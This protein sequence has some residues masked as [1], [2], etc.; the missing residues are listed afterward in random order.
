MLKSGTADIDAASKL[1][2]DFCQQGRFGA[3]T[4]KKTIETSIQKKADSKSKRPE[5]GVEDDQSLCSA[6]ESGEAV[7][8]KKKDRGVRLVCLPCK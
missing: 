5:A 3:V 4:P 1:S 2:Q 7:L 8:T 6:S